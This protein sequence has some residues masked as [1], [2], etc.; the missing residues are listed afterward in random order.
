MWAI[1]G[2]GEHVKRNIIPV[3]ERIDSVKVKYICVR[4][5]VALEDSDDRFI[6]VEDFELILKDKDVNNVYIG[7]PIST[8]FEFSRNALLARK[9][10]ICEK[11]LTA[12]FKDTCELFEIARRQNVKLMEVCMYLH[13]KQYSWLK[14]IVNDNF[15]K[16]I[17]VNVE[18][19]IPHLEPDNIR[20]NKNACGGA[21]LDVGYYPIS[22]I[23]ILFGSPLR[24]DSKVYFE[25]A[26]EVDTSGVL[27]Y[28]YEKFY[29]VGSWAI[30]QQY[31]NQI[32]LIFNGFSLKINRVFSKPYSY[33][34]NVII[35][36]DDG[37]EQVVE[38]GCD[39]QFA[40]MFNFFIKNDMAQ[41]GCNTTMQISK[42]IDL[43]AK[44]SD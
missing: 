22:M 20:Y 19:H 36:K 10:V 26:Y 14:K 16:L 13:H 37:T 33:N 21:L 12:S 2:Y 3:L 41:L 5:K 11:T 17:K 27:I 35:V 6:F 28:F 29:C 7:T 15:D 4:S 24:T 34:S 1:I 9:N 39:D 44:S 40:N 38:I 18:F 30:G 42:A 43:I 32:T 8:H 25:E 23:N 31:K